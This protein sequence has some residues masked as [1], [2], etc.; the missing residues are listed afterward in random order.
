MTVDEA[1]E[2]VRL[3]V[4]EDIGRSAQL[5]KSARVSGSQSGG[6]Q[7]SATY[8]C[9][10]REAFHKVYVSIIELQKLVKIDAAK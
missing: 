4:L 9:G 1:L 5:E 2:K 10:Q 7:V 8:H 3:D 6:G